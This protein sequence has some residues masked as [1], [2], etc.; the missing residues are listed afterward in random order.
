MRK[1]LLTLVMAALMSLAA[2]P[3]KA[4][5]EA[6]LSGGYATLAMADLNDALS[7]SGTV[8]STSIN[9]GFYVALDA[10]IAIFPFLKL[11][12]RVEYVQANAGIAKNLGT[13]ST[14]NA[15]IV[16]LE[17]GLAVD[18][19]LPLTGLSVRGG[20]WGGYGSATATISNKNIATGITTGTLYQGSGFVAEGLAAIRYDLVPMVAI[21]LEAG[22][23][24]NNIA[25]MSDT[26]GN[27][28]KKSATEDMAFDFSGAN[29]GLGLSVGF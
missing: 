10:G 26:S 13:E 7:K 15:N 22:Y 9:S 28:L 6:N 17:L 20:V 27:S 24:L 1:S 11:V 19:S 14:V 16:P 4:F 29:I 2:V 21:S 25:K 5:F 18:A 23:R 3:A 12:P 8:S